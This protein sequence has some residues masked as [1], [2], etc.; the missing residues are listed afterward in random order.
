VHFAGG[1]RNAAGS[2]ILESALDDVTVYD[3]SDDVV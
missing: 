1:Y 2:S 3:L